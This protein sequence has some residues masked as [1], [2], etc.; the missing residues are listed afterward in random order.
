M[1][2][3]PFEITNYNRTTEEL[4]VFWLFCMMVAGKNA[5]GTAK[6]LTVM[7][8]E[9]P[10]DV[11]PFDWLKNKNVH[12]WIRHHRTG[13]YTRLGAGITQSLYLDLHKASVSDLEGVH[14]VGPKSARFFV[15]HSRKS[16][17]C[18]VLDTH[19]MKYLQSKLTEQ[20]PKSTPSKSLYK[21]FED[22]FLR[23]IGED[24]PE[25]TVAEADLHIWTNYKRGLKNV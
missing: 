2:I 16:V 1:I 6:K 11:L 19:I 23:Y 21:K 24:F 12:N 8:E 18:A 14:G 22:M 3:D 17:S 20:I 10:L 25:M 13:Q 4:Q 15:L 7:M 5:T 9:K